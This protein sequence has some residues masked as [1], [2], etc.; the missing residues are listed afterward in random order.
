MM[1][2]F[3]KL[4]RVSLTQ[5]NRPLLIMVKQFRLEQNFSCSLLTFFQNFIQ[6]P[7]FCQHFHQMRGDDDVFITEWISVGHDVWQRFCFFRI[8][9][10]ESEDKGTKCIETQKYWNENNIL[11]LHCSII[12]DH[13]L[14]GLFRI[15]SQWEVVP[16]E[17]EHEHE[18]NRNECKVTIRVDVQCKQRWFGF[19]RVVETVLSDKVK[20][21]YERWFLMAISKLDSER[22]Q[23]TQP[24]TR[25]LCQ[26]RAKSQNTYKKC[27]SETVPCQ[28]LNDS[29]KT[30]I[31]A[32]TDSNSFQ[33]LIQ[34]RPS[35]GNELPSLSL[36]TMSSLSS[37]SQSF[38]PSLSNYPTSLLL[39]YK[40][41]L[42]TGVE[43]QQIMIA[44]TFGDEPSHILLS[45]HILDPDLQV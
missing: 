8:K 45:K 3:P 25:E 9:L 28:M 4:V 36:P 6:S 19:Q 33:Q 16:S 30:Q 11:R 7:S 26:L 34:S 5:T 41:K 10:D 21:F 38:F 1:P 42:T 39:T 27:T 44:T 37:P 43:P 20:E 35:P 17:R 15:E 14:A 18:H 12:P 31:D 32:S 23:A 13:T 2:P 24:V 40:S 22:E 29:L